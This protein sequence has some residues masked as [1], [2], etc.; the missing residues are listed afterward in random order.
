MYKFRD[1]L[2][3]CFYQFLEQANKWI[4]LENIEIRGAEIAAA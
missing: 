4:A 1:S 3:I 2:R